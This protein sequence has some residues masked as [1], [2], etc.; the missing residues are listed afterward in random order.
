MSPPDP[1]P[2]TRAVMFS[3]ENLTE[4]AALPVDQLNLRLAILRQVEIQNASD[5]RLD[6]EGGV[7][8]QIRALDQALVRKTGK[9]SNIVVGMQTLSLRGTA[10]KQGE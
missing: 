6:M 8:D 4:L 7:R 2:M 5:P 1:L 3:E 10:V 9:P